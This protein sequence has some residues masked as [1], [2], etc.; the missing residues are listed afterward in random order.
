MQTQTS[1]TSV[2]G[3]VALVALLALTVVAASAGFASAEVPQVVPYQGY[4]SRANGTPVEGSVTVSFR[5]Y[6][7]S[8]D[9]APVWTETVSNVQVAGGAFYV[10]LGQLSPIGDYFSDGANRYLG[11]AINNDPE[12]SPRQSIGSVPYALVT[13]NSLY[14]DGQ[15]SDYYVTEP[16]LA[17]ALEGLELGGDYITQEELVNILNDYITA[18]ELGDYLTIEDINNI[19]GDYVTR[20]ELTEILNNYVTQ[21]QLNNYVTQEQLNNYVTIDQLGDYVTRTEFETEVNNL[22]TQIDELRN[23]IDNLGNLNAPYIL[24]VSEQSSSGRFE[25]GGKFG[26]AAASEMCRVTFANEPTAHLCSPEEVKSAISRESWSSANQAAIDQTPTWTV[27]DMVR[28]DSFGNSS[29][30]NSCHNFNYP[31]GHIAR[32]TALTVFFGTNIDL[33]NANANT[34]NITRETPCADSMPVLCCR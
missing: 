12:A 23:I 25:F 34:V 6:E 22:Q 11:I 29:Q 17:A 3:R 24:G 15:D 18:N 30:A 32:G 1:T 4:L 5:L 27:T 21:E 31:T 8:G 14:F 9:A 19:L 13:Q 2:V 33:G 28:G 7:N 26:M 16:E 20:T 10:Y